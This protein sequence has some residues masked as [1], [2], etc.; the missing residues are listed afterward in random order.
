MKDL[1][2][3]NWDSL[4]DIALCTLCAFFT[5]FIL[6]RISGKRTLAKLNAFDFIVT[7]TLGSTLSSM[8][9]NKVTLTEGTVALTIIIILQYTL[10]WLSRA[11]PT[12]EKIINCNPTLLYYNGAF[13][14]DAMKREGITE[15]EIYA[16]IRNFRLER[17]DEV[18]AVVLELNGEISVIKKSSVVG[19][20]SSLHDLKNQ[21]P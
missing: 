1:F 11:S 2:F 7:V 4:A 14:N 16:E 8:I 9:L 13:M 5:L 20:T 3:K 15:E 19:G 18:R 10:A 12:M 6:V 17:L 21:K